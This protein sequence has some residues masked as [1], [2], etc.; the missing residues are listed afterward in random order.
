MDTITNRTFDEIQIGDSHQRIHTVREQDIQLFA[1]VSGD[2]NPVHLDT[3]YAATTPFKAQIAH[4]MYTG[5]L[6]SAVL[7]MDLPGPGTIYLGQNI[8]F[9]K[10]VYVG[11]EL[12]VQLTVDSKH[13]SKP[14]VTLACT[15]SNQK[16]KTVASGEATAMAP[17]EKISV[18]APPLPAIQLS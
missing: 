3:E 16:G 11:D 2:R 5:A 9:K 1:A 4:G 6:I 17:T 15:V 10:P 14:I 7:G 8:A 12:T 13:D 18:T